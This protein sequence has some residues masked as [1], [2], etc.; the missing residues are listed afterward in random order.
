MDRIVGVAGAVGIL[1]LFVAAVAAG[2]VM[3]WRGTMFDAFDRWDRS[4]GR[5]RLRTNVLAVLAVVA[6]VL[7]APIVLAEVRWLLWA[8]MLSR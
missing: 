2:L 7:Q 5:A 8:V 1:A 3:A 6:V 4:R